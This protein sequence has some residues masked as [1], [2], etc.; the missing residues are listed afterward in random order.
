MS[1]PD[2]AVAGLVGAE[3]EAFVEIMFLAASSD[4]EFSEIERR[5]FL[6]SVESLTD[7]RLS[8][9]ILEQLLARAASELSA[10]NRSA[11]LAAVRDRLPHQGARRAA[12]SLAVQVA[13]SDGVI[14]TGERELILEAA[15]ILGVA[16]EDAANLVRKL[17]GV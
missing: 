15:E 6:D 16:R 17:A 4:G 2:F 7:A 13:A 5:H 3:L 1:E 12:L 8:Q 9:G 14:R 10:S 11:R